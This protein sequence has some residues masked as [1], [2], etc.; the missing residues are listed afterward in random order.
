MWRP[1]LQTER[2]GS[3]RLNERIARIG[4]EQEARIP[5]ADN[6]GSECG[7]TKC[8]FRQIETRWKGSTGYYK[9]D[10]QIFRAA[11]LRSRVPAV[12]VPGHLTLYS[13][14]CK[15]CQSTVPAPWA[16][17]WLLTRV[18]LFRFMTGLH[19][20]SG[21]LQYLLGWRTFSLAPNLH[22]L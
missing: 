15:P 10:P 22:S 19:L 5:S 16:F 9:A 11:A 1:S 20:T 21:S 4:L 3:P 6:A 12:T 18:A 8:R 14:A 13:H 7:P 17:P 2:I